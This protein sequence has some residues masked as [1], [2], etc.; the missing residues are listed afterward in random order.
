MSNDLE[1]V[2]TKYLLTLVDDDEEL[3]PED[4]ILADGLVDSLG[5]IRLVAH[6]EEVVGCKIPPKDFTIEH[7][8]SIRAMV[9][10]LE[11]LVQES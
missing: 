11:T 5:L 3:S 2:I 7:F 10:Y 9:S 4:E 6:I 8:G 1:Q